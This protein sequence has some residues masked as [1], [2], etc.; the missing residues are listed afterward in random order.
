MTTPDEDQVQ[1]IWQSQPILTV[2]MT[3][4]QLRARAARF[5]KETRK[6]NLIDFVSFAIVALVFGIGAATL[7]NPLTRAGTLLLAL[8]AA[9]GVYSVRRFHALTARRSPESTASTCVAWYQEQ[10][11][12]QRDVA[13]SRPWGLALGL[14]GLVLLLIG[15]VDSGVPWTFSVVLA[16]MGL[17]VSVGV[18]IHGKILAGRWQEEINALQRLQG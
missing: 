7:Q 17:F 6:R 14:P 10:L 15:Y 3:P 16:G 5:E 2:S 18:I 4:E 8:W 11:E 1:S 9:V 13:L 12:R